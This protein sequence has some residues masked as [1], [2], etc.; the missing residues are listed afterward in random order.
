VEDYAMQDS[1]T[2]PSAVLQFR[3][4][5]QAKLR[6]GVRRAIETV[7]GEE[8]LAA[9]GAED[10]VRTPMRRGYRHGTTERTLTTREGTRPITVPR[11][12]LRAPDG[13]V[14]EFQSTVVPRYARRTREVDEALLGCYFGGVNSRRIRTALKPLF[15]EAH[16]LTWQQRP[17][18]DERYA[19]VFLDAVHLRVRLAGRVISV[20]VLAALGVTAS[21]QKQL[22]ALQLAA[23]EATA[24]WSGLLADLQRRGL[25]A[26]LLVITDGHAGLKKA[27]EAWPTVQV[28]RCTTHKGR[29][30][31]DACPVHARPELRR[32]YHRI[33]YA[34]DG[35]A[36]RAAYDACL[37]KW[38]ALCAP[39]ARSLEEAGLDLLTFYRFPKATWKSLRTT[40]ALEN[41]NRE[42]RRR[43]KTQASFSTE[44][45]A[46]TV[47]F[48]LVAVGQIVF[49]KIDGH[50]TLAAFLVKEQWSQA[51]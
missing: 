5:L 31:E 43:T 28:Q 47:L 49:R 38:T 4:D 40:N 3:Q 7:L 39:V 24:S 30:L 23:A 44:A 14:Q 27:L 10:H 35:L 33:I 51:A 46:L 1:S 26:P 29:N 19:V 36:A 22:V 48:G 17:L 34:A 18:T 8:L 16:F 11:A 41:L 32:D 21:G 12:R 42:F 20:P 2:A 6:E 15:G 25:P 45:S 13:T 9:L 50:P 37:K